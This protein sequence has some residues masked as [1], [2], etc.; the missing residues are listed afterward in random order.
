M[1]NRT[2]RVKKSKREHNYSSR[3]TAANISVF[4]Q[5]M[6]KRD[7]TTEACLLAKF[8]GNTNMYYLKHSCRGKTY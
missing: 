5:R 4:V 1:T 2:Y 6:G 8:A 3:G 7:S